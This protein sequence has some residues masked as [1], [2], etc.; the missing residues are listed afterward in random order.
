V[1]YEGIAEEGYLNNPYRYARVL[2]AFVPEVYPGTHDS[3]AL[4][5]RI[6]KGFFLGHAQ[7]GRIGACRLPL[8]PATT[9]ELTGNTLLLAYQRYFANRCWARC[10][11]RF[12][13]QSAATFYSDNFATR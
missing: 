8:L 9:G 4:A 2:G 5:V 10:D 1:S 13:Q 12:Y 11:Y 6:M 7:R 3:Q